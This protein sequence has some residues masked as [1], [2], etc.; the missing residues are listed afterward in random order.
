MT[1]L[2]RRAFGR[3]TNP[4]RNQNQPPS[5][6]NT[7]SPSG[8]SQSSLG[9]PTIPPAP[10]SPSLTQ[11]MATNDQAHQANAANGKV[12]FFFREDYAN[13]IVKGNFM[14]LANKPQNIELGEWLAHQRK[15]ITIT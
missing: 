3:G 6:A 10:P 4:A 7:S 1:A 5:R 15:I 14:T 9:P 13:F 2:R 8:Y 11:T 12:P